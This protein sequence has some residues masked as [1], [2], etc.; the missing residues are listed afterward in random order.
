M[1]RRVAL[2]G[3]TGF[4]GR[5]VSAHLVARGIDVV[6][7]VRPESTHTAPAGVAVARA[8]LAAAA[9]RKAFGGAD[10]VVHLAGAINAIDSEIYTA[11]NV[12]G[13][14]AVAE[15]THEVGARLIHVSSLAAAG[16]ASAAAPRAEDDPPNPLT[17]YGRS[18]L[19]SEEI[20]TR[21]PGLAWTI[22]RPAAVYG[23]G[24]RVML[25]LFRM[26]SRGI[27]PLVGR[28]GAAYTFVHVSDVVRAIDAAIDA[29]AYG[30]ICFVGHPRSVTAREILEAI[31]VAV[32]RPARLIRVPNALALVAAAAGDLASRM[33]GRP[34][35]LNWW[36]YCELSAEGFVCRL[37]RL[38][39]R[40]GVVAAIDLEAGMRET[41]EWY[42]HEGWLK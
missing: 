23:P 21:T 38:R 12:E 32:G 15:A 40:L 22:L 2:T 20:V 8:P 7:V 16:P 30:D 29:D 34:L 28:P 39:D 13:T 3:A 6:A 9:L 37:D 4:I 36:R 42:R 19:A 27:L 5:H 14:R 31:G 35:P 26:T 17:P 25:P 18:K 10:T 41:A 11:V 1:I 24:D 33:T